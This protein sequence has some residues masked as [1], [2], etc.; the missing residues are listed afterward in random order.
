MSVHQRSR[1]HFAVAAAALVAL[2]ACS[3]GTPDTSAA[4]ESTR[5]TAASTTPAICEGETDC[6]DLGEADV[7]GDGALDQ[8]ARVDGQIEVLT[9]A[10][11][12][13][14]TDATASDL[15]ST[16]E[17]QRSGG[18][19]G[20]FDV[21]GRAGAEIVV[22]QQHL[23]GTGLYQV[24]TWQD[25]ALA[26]IAAPSS[27]YSGS[28]VLW[29]LQSGEGYR[30]AVR[31]TG[32]AERPIEV[33]LVEDSYGGSGPDT[34]R[35]TVHSYTYEPES[36]VWEGSPFFDADSY[37]AV[38]PDSAVL[39]RFPWLCGDNTVGAAPEAEQQCGALAQDV[40][41][42][43][44]LSRLPANPAGNGGW[45]FGGQTN[46]DPC[47]DLSYALAETPGGTGSSPMR[48]MLFHRGDYTGTG[49][50]CAFGRTAVTAATSDRVDVT[51]R[52]PRG[53]ESNAEA[54][55]MA[56]VSYVWDG[57]GVSMHGTLPDELVQMTRC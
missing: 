28:P 53:M 31:C 54:S 25:N 14:R 4:N 10:G 26:S 27:L 2:T 40:A 44:G 39:E 19:V 46:F 13:A 6:T 24:F 18:F 56:E 12:R 3:S 52:F 17:L 7:D 47:A 16:E 23:A 9:A 45:T 32:I 41:I 51:Y 8:I 49:T 21:D 35:M 15:L 38:A 57:E 1:F 48:V 34:P 37:T 29:Q 33:W 22:A 30:S 50:A 55:G 5:T 20:A 11:S 36:P 42:A 43:D